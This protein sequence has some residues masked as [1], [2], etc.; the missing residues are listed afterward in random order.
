MFGD[1]TETPNQSISATLQTAK[2]LFFRQETAN[3]D[4]ELSNYV[5]QENAVLVTNAY[6]N[7]GSVV[8]LNG[9][10]VRVPKGTIYALL[11]ASGCGKT[12]LLGCITGRRSLNSGHAG[13]FGMKPGSEDLTKRIGY[14]PQETG[15]HCDFTVEEALLFYGFVFGMKKSV[16]KERIEFLVELLMLPGSDHKIGDLSGGEQR[17]VSLAIA[18]LHEPELL[19]LDEPTVGV[20]P[21]VREIIWKHFLDITRT[22][23]VTIIITTHYIEETSQADIIGFLRGGY[24]VAEDNPKTLLKRHNATSLENVFL[25]LS[26]EQNSNKADAVIVDAWSKTNCLTIPSLKSD[27][28]NA[29]IWK[30]YVWFRKNYN[31]LIVIMLLPVFLMSLFCLAIG[32]DPIDLK[33]AVVN[34]EA[35]DEHCN[36]TLSCDSNEISCSYLK[37]LEQRGLILLPYQTEHDAIN[38]VQQGETYASIFIKQNYSK[39]L[40]TRVHHWYRVKPKDLEQS[41]IDVFRDVSNKHISLFIQVY[42]YQSYETFFYNYID[43]CGLSRKEMSVPLQLNSLYHGINPNFTDFSVPGAILSIAF[44]IGLILTAWAML[45]ERNEGSLERTLVVGINTTELM[46]SHVIVQ[47]V[48]VIAQ[49]LLTMT[50]IFAGFGMTAKGS[51]VLAAILLFL[52]GFSGLCFGLLISCLCNSLVGITLIA[53]GT[54]F[55]VIL[56]SG[57]IWPIEAMH[58]WLKMFAV[59][60]PLTQPTQSLR[61][62]LHRG[63]ETKNDGIELENCDDE[64]NAV[65]VTDAFKNYGSVVVLKSLNATVP[66]GSIYA[67]IGASGCGKTTLLGCI[68]GRKTLNSGHASVF[69]L[70]PGSEELTKRI[71]YMPQETGL[72]DAFSVQETLSFYGRVLGM[73]RGLIKERTEFLVKLLKLPGPDHKVSELSGGQKRRVS[74]AIAFLHEPELLILDEP[75]VGV[76]PVL[77]EIIWKYFLDITE[78][79]N[80]TILITTHYIEETSQADIVGFMRGG[81][82]IAEDNPKSLLERHKVT[83]LEDMFLKLS[84]EQNDNKHEHVVVNTWRHDYYYLTI[85]SLK[86]DHMKALI[87]KNCLWLLKNYFFLI[88]IM[89][90]PVFFISIFCLAI[91]HD[92]VNLKVAVV[93]GEM[94]EDHCNDTLSCDNNEISCSFL[95]NLEKRGLVLLPYQTEHDAINSVQ[96]G[97]TYASIVIKQNHSKAL[98]TRVHHW[99]RVKAN[100]LEQSTIDVFRDV[101]NKQISLFIQMYLYQSYETFFYNYLDSCEIRPKE[102]KIP[103]QFNSL[104]HGIS[105]NFTDFSVAGV[106]L[107]I[108]FEIGLLLT[109]YVMIV[110]KNEASLERTLVVGINKT[111]LMLSHAFVQ[112]FVMVA[113]MLLTTA[114]TFAVF[115]MTAKGSLV[116]TTIL[117]SLTGFSGVC[118]GLLISCI[119]DS[120][121]GVVLIG[122][123]TY[124]TVILTSGLVWPTEGMHPWL[125]L[126]AVF[127]PLSKPTES[128]R[129]IL[130]R[131]WTFLHQDVY[132]GFLSVSAWSVVFLLL[133]IITME[134]QKD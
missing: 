107:S 130:H 80:V 67:L 94:V 84:I 39:A 91:G 58:P 10:N 6:K 64:E 121:V 95:K 57:L 78:R 105:P 124:F 16:I 32:H 14:M 17:R 114:C 60:F 7:Y 3:D 30:H 8:V 54:Y 63:H 118:F 48:V 71:G 119:C 43:A 44:V 40:R 87:W 86:L 25:K 49:M 2:N 46:L 13:V 134:I 1:L 133:S 75:T 11:G 122:M 12:T 70:K 106:L 55:T 20:D 52:T 96:Q 89:L 27:H 35:I 109:A 56:T 34:D 61:S 68:T 108:S 76:D 65:L 125:K 110:E 51:L 77:R 37:Y 33:V 29:L 92:P 100:D 117:L 22:K 50:C 79:K 69:G 101:S 59:L 31:L 4:I 126:F 113:Q 28:I 66:K 120:L 23:N 21:V 127:F 74:L 128:L 73:E 115:G 116:L 38:S 82:L 129:F 41:T 53:M 132:F 15:L 45:V 24:L 47:F 83:S 9:L 85:P 90:L 62:I 93:N 19:I 18:F 72:Y 36:D 99:Y 131:G 103:L 112:F 81:Y 42:L 97:E 104:Y 123:G 102:L 111:E 88:V 5:D 98:R 26:I